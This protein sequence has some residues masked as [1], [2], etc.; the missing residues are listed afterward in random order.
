MDSQFFTIDILATLTGLVA[1]IM[2]LIQHSKG[3][4]DIIYNKI[5]KKTDGFPTQALVVIISE[6]M[7]FLVMFFQGKLDSNLAIFLTA[8]N[9]LVTA[10][11]AI[12]SYDSIAKKDS[13]TNTENTTTN[14]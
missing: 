7:L 13:V 11:V 10:T 12:K 1:C 4:I 14:S 9:G 6:I 3:I 2:I 8:I 5:C